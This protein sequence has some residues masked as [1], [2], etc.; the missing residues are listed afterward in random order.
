MGRDAASL[1]EKQVGVLEWIRDGCRG[2][3]LEADSGRRITARALHRRGLVAV[4]GRGAA[5]TAS[6]TKAGRA[7]LEAHPRAA[8]TLDAQ[9][10]DLIRRVLAADGRLELGDDYGVKLAHE[11]L[12]RKSDHSP[13]RP[14]GWRL[15][16]RN[17]GSWSESRYEV[18]LVRHFDDLVD[19]M[20]VPVPRHVGRSHP[21]VQAY[22]ADRDRQWVSTAHVDRAARILQAIA[23]EA[24]RRGLDVMATDGVP[25]RV[26]AY[27]DR[28]TSRS[29]LVLRSPAGVYGVRIRELSAPSD[30]RV[31]RRPWNQRRTRAAWLDARDREFVSTGTLELIVEGPG[32]GYNGDRQRDTKTITLEE[33]LPRI[34]RVIEIYRLE[35]ELRDQEREREAADRRR[36]WEAAMVEARARYD[37]Q[38]RWEAFEQRSRDWHT[39]TGHRGFLSAAREAL[40]GYRG[41][42]RDDVVAQLDLA[43]RRLDALDPISHP[44]LLVPEVPDP[45]PGDLK[46][47]LR[48][49]SPSGP[50]AA[51]W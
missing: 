49:W 22:L 43:E 33:R 12:V 10:D 38:I 48:G 20:P 44:E 50:D 39:V 14:R 28:A 19:A 21:T 40:S 46:P 25:P 30:T 8:L 29:H 47:Y 36:R 4:K 27:S 7:W 24:P 11:P 6:I 35:A 31:V 3:E 41:P 32:T 5:W 15:D 45:G 37:A 13:N 26:D 17:A 1:T 18:R 51:G 16:L 34:F 9:V 2:G 23:D 42:A